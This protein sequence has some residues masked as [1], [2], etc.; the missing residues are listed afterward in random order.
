MMIKVA[1]VLHWGLR[2]DYLT[3]QNPSQQHGYEFSV[4]ESVWWTERGVANG[5]QVTDTRA[6][7]SQ[8]REIVFCPLWNLKLKNNKYRNNAIAYSVSF[9]RTKQYW[10][11]N[12]NGMLFWFVYSL[13]RCAPICRFYKF[14]PE[15]MITPECCCRTSTPVCAQTTLMPR[16]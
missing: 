8:Y 5:T 15:Q 16:I 11:W 3:I 6:I 10:F 1:L 13:L 7:V 2:L 9:Y 14:S 4:S 12:T